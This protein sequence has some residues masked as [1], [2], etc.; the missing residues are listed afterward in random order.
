MKVTFY[1]GVGK[2][3]GANFL[4]KIPKSS[5]G[6]IKALVDCGLLQGDK[7]SEKLNWSPFPYNPSEMDYLFVTHAHLDHVGKIPKLVRDGF[8][9]KIYSNPETKELAFHILNDAVGLLKREAENTGRPILYDENDIN[10]AFSM[11]NTIHYHTKT[12]FGDFS[13]YLKDS[14][15]ILGSSM[16]MFTVGD[17]TITFTGDLGNSPSTLLKDTEYIDGT[18]YIVMESVYGDRNHEPKELRSQ[19]LLE[20][21][22]DNINRGG[23][24]LIPSFSLERTQVLLSEINDFVERG[25]IR[26]IPVFV[27][28]P[29]AI[30]ITEVYRNYI[31]DFNDATQ[32]KIKGGDDIFAFPRLQYTDDTLESKGIENKPSPKIIIAGSGMSVGGRIIRHEMELLPDPKNTILFVGYQSLGSTGRNILEGHKKITISGREVPIRAKIENIPGYSAHKDSDHLLDFVEK[33]SSALKCAFVVMGEPK[34]SLFLTQRINDS[35]GSGKAK[36]PEWGVEYNLE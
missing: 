16:M 14:G 17:K 32:I 27:D 31:E 34:A 4:L 5:G 22:K 6:E 25:D 11:W 13:L 23:T 15:H 1:G 28:S 33:S 30:K 29:L 24:L 7:D 18:N 36:Y 35:L 21:I 9:G 10:K 12:D 26:P 2:V 8:N 20:V 3:T 19:K